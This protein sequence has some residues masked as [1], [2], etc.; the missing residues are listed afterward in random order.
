MTLKEFVSTVLEQIVAG[1][2]DAQKKVSETGGE[3]NPRLSGSNLSARQEK[4]LMTFSDLIQPVE[5]DVAMTATDETS[6]GGR[7][8]VF[9]MA[10]G[11]A[12][13]ISTDQ[14][15]SRIKFIVPVKLPR[16]SGSEK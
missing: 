6:G 16:T 8:A 3:V 4:A 12:S 2:S 1:V 9:G 14:V 15:V 10:S 11:S 7:V 5:F 13:K